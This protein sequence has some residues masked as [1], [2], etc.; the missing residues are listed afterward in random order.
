[1]LPDRVELVDELPLTSASKLDE[2]QLL[3]RVGLLPPGTGTGT[4]SSEGTVWRS[5]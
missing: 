2:R 5:A 3:R 4:G 1:M